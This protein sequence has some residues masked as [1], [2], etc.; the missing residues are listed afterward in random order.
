[1]AKEEFD[2]QAFEDKLKDAA[3]DLIA[4]PRNRRK[5]AVY[6]IGDKDMPNTSFIV[7][8]YPDF[9]GLIIRFMSNGKIEMRLYLS[10][11]LLL[12]EEEVLHWASSTCKSWIDEFGASVEEV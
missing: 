8:T 10:P 9:D 12:E 4:N 6:E 3:K 7:D 2:V 1:M 5:L 11:Q